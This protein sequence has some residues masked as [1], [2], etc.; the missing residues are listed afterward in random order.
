MASGALLGDL[1]VPG[2]Q[3]TERAPGSNLLKYRIRSGAKQLFPGSSWSPGQ[4][5]QEYHAHSEPECPKKNLLPLKVVNASMPA[6][7]VWGS[8]T[9]VQ[10]TINQYGL[11]HSMAK[12]DFSL[13]QSSVP[14]GEHRL[15]WFLTNW[16]LHF[17]LEFLRRITNSE[18]H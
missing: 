12:R 11:I 15:E 13:E 8:S 6:G 9:Y 17:S 10:E 5:W 7:F 16:V 1:C 2:L 14:F 4:W 18:P 3:K